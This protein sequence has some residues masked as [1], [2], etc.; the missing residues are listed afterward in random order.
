MTELD[1]EMVMRDIEIENVTYNPSNFSALIIKTEIPSTIMV[2]SSGKYLITGVSNNTDVRRSE[3]RLFEQLRS[4]GISINQVEKAEIRNIVC[5]AN[6]EQQIDLPNL[7]IELGLENTE[8]EPEQSPFLVYRPPTGDCVMTISS[9]GKTVIT[10]LT[11]EEQG[12]RE[13]KNF[14]EDVSFL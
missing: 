8:Y 14:K 9:S 7:M 10:G 2:F 13:F 1:L 11:T 5:T 4:L 3:D 6:I 12:E